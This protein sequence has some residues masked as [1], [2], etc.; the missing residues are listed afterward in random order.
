MLVNNAGI[1]RRGT[2]FDAKA[3]DD[4]DATLAVNL[5]GPYL[6]TTAFLDPLKATKGRGGE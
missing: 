4:W 5:D 2:L 6:V 1:V 3:R